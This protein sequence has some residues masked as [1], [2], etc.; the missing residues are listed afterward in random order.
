VTQPRHLSLRL[1]AHNGGPDHVATVKALVE[2]GV[3][4]TIADRSGV[5]PLAHAKSSGFTEIE[6]TIRGAK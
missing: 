3:G 1:K 5:T 4:V 6:D 2:S